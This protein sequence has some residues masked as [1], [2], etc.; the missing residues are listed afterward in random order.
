MS[1]PNMNN[2][3]IVGSIL[4]YISVVLLGFDT[5]F[6]SSQTFITLCYVRKFY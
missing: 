1:S 5:R 3:I 6:V 4:T 2:I